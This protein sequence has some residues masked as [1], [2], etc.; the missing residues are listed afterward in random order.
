M[1][2]GGPHDRNTR[3]CRKTTQQTFPVSFLHGL[4]LTCTR[5]DPATV[6]PVSVAKQHNKPFLRV[7]CMGIPHMYKGRPHDRN[8]CQCRKTTQ[9]TFPVSFLHGLYL[10][11]TW[12]DP[13]TVTPASVAKQL[14]SVLHGLYLTCTQE[15]P[16]TLTTASVPK[17]HNKP[18]LCLFCMG[19]TYMDTGGPHDRNTR[20]C[21]KTLQQVFPVYFLPGLYLT[22][23]REDPT[24]LTPASV[25]KQHN[26]PFL[27]TFCMGYTSHTGGPHDRNTRRCRK[28]TKF[29]PVYLVDGLYL[30]CTR[31]DPTTATPASIAK[32]HNEPFLC[33]FC[34]G[35]TSYVH[36]RTPRP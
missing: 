11:C 25:A 17:P 29:F 33:L 15:D 4:Y 2:T 7:F 20:H 8:T 36:G 13:T 12:E 32:Q 24:T 23:T 27:C 5:E 31:E 3:Q 6:T 21:R 35:S 1:Y 19:Y 26:K 16:T 22:C 14:L 10:T 30:T 34:M 28:T 18:F 9:Q